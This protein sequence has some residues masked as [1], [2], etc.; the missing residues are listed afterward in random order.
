MDIVYIRGGDKH[1]VE[2]AAAAGMLYGIRHDYIAYA[3]V[4]MLDIR[5]TRYD[6]REYLARVRD[7]RP[8]VALAPDYE[9][10][11]QWTG[12]QRQIDDLRPLVDHIMVC[13]KWHGAVAHIPAD[14]IVAVSVP[15]RTYAGFLPSFSALVGRRV[16]L[17]G[18]NLDRQTRLI[19][20]YNS[21]GASVVSLDTDQ[22]AL[23]GGH[24]QWLS[25][26]KWRQVRCNSV[27]DH[28]LALASAIAMVKR[29]QFAATQKQGYFE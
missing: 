27:P 23:K 3:K 24:G 18:G 28:E 25:E 14:C 29:L 16:H 10:A 13:P 15:A 1:A 8:V 5:W 17:L 4:H 12:L 20:A 6:W 7:L 21:A 26:G 19:S 2:I 11:W 22:M 9:H